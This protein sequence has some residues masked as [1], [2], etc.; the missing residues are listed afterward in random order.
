MGRGGAGEKQTRNNRPDPPRNQARTRN[1][2]VF[3]TFKNCEVRPKMAYLGV[4]KENGPLTGLVTVFHTLIWKLILIA[5]IRH[6]LNIEPFD[7]YK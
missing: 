6:D 1:F 7:G 3:V 2:K 5:Y 4:N